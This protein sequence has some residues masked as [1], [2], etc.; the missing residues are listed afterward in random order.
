LGRTLADAL[1]GFDIA[2][3]AIGQDDERL[4]RQR[5]RFLSGESAV[6]A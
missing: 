3:A 4:R 6:P 2:Y 5:E 1:T